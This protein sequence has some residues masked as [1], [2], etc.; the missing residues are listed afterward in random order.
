MESTFV[1]AVHIRKVRH[2]E[3][4]DIPLSTDVRKNL[5]LTGK[6]G[7]GKTSV[8]DTLAHHLDF[9]VS[10]DF[11]TER[12]CTSRLQSAQKDLEKI[13]ID[14][15]HIRQRDQK[16]KVIEVYQKEL[17]NWITGVVADCSSYS[18]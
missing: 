1:T 9:L 8:L 3:N 15:S 2:L 16:K 6:N 5:I 7:S 18:T 4:I 12:E 11:L 14:D 17:S 10:N 13:I